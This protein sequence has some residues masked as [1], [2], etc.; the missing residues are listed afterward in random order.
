MVIYQADGTGMA[1]S[2]IRN[3]QMPIFLN[4][5]IILEESLYFTLGLFS[6]TSLS[7][8]PRG[9]KVKDKRHHIFKHV[10]LTTQSHALVHA[11]L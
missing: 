10:L 11:I 1:K 9:T 6:V 5:G 2:D 8:S 7:W 4:K 3:H